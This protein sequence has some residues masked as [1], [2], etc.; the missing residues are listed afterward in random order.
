[1]FFPPEALAAEYEKSLNL[2][3]TDQWRRN[4]ET[5]LNSFWDETEARKK[6]TIKFSASKRADTQ[7]T[8]A[9]A[10]AVDKEALIL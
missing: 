10:K 9:D 7:L 8:Q 5:P 2:G 6:H 4:R 1:M 3:K